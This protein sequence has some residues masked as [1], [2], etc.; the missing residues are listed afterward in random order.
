MKTFNEFVDKKDREAKKQLSI[1]KALLE[2]HNFGVKD[3]LDE[4]DPYIF[5]QNPDK[6]LS[7]EGIRIYKIGDDLAFRV[8]KS[9]K[10]HPYGAA[11]PLQVED[12]FHDLLADDIDEE[13]AGKE[14]MQAIVEELRRFFKKSA[15]AEKELRS[16][17]FGKDPLNKVVVKSTGTDYSNQIYNK[18]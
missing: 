10:T 12:M 13:K 8:Q 6:N 2:K 5:V 1:L 3:N 15:Q 14:V 9:E 4:E 11:Y 16:G 18:T 17:E 7:F